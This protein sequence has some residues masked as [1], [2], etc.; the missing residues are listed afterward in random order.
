MVAGALI[1][2]TGEG[3]AAYAGRLGEVLA[4][5]PANEAYPTSVIGAVELSY[6]HLS[7]DAKAV[8]DLCAWWAADGLEPALLTEAPRGDWWKA[9]KEETPEAVQALAADAGRFRA[10]FISLTTG[11]RSPPMV[12][13]LKCT[14]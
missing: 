2:A 10:A 13:P 4:H 3:F 12:A 6:D 11:C 14:A 9:R 5:K 8:A 7:P 1:R